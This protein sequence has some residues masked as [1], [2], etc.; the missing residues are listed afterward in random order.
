MSTLERVAAVVVGAVVVTV[1]VLLLGLRDGE[2]EPPPADASAL[3]T[4][5][6]T[7][8]TPA[9]HRFGETVTAT[10]EALVPKTQ[11]EP[12][13]LTGTG[14]FDP[15]QV[16]DRKRELF[17]AGNRWLV[18]YT[19]SLQCVREACVPDGRTGE[20]QFETGAIRWRVPPPPGRRFRDRRLDERSVTASWE[21]VTVVRTLP[22]ED[23]ADVRWRS[24]LVELPA[25]GYSVS[26]RAFSLVLLGVA[27]ALV[28]AAA[29]LVVWWLLRERRAAVVAA[30]VEAAAEASP[31]ERALALVGKNGHGDD[32]RIA[33]ETLA[34]ELRLEGEQALAAEAETLAWSENEPDERHVSS[35]AAAVRETVPA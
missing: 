29:A 5:A 25:P 3:P 16:V 8:M 13:T 18:R 23:V 35:L 1:L 4:M 2:P 7:T 33:L 20:F 11:L 17:D 21:P 30:A 27:L 10:I 15:Y 31:L 14:S 32:R 9:A 6:R 12:E 24:T 26:P 28:F 19:I 22:S 34:R